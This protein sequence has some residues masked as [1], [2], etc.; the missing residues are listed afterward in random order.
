MLRRMG[1][2]CTGQGISLRRPSYYDLPTEEPTTFAQARHLKPFEHMHLHQRASAA[3]QRS[4]LRLMA[5][6]LS[7][8]MHTEMHS[9]L[10]QPILLTE[11]SVLT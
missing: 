6:C 3:V 8:G 1:T 2:I 10:A 7:I 4:C 9:P 5:E 11:E